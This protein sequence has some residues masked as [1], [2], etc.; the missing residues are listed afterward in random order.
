MKKVRIA[1]LKSRLSHYLRYVQRGR[2][3]LVYNRDRAIA[4][5]DPV[6]DPEA[7]AVGD[8]TSELERSG[9]LRP[10]VRALPKDWLA[11]RVGMHANVTGAL[12][13]ERDSGR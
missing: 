11:R 2:S 9:S 13:A 5:I 12:L 1:E 8:W 3:V 6:T 4:R 10:P 7:L